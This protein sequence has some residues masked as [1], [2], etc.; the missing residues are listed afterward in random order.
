[1]DKK[2]F[3]QSFFQ[4]LEEE[5][6][7][8]I[9]RNREALVTENDGEVDII[10]PEK[11]LDKLFELVEKDENC[12][13]TGKI[14]D[15]T[16]PLL[17][18]AVGEDFNILLDFQIRGIGFCGTYVLPEKSLLENRVK[19]NGLN[20]LNR[21]YHFLALFTHS[22]FYHGKFRKY[23]DVLKS[24]AM[25][26]ENRKVLKDFY[27][28]KEGELFLEYLENGEFE[29]VLGSRLKLMIKHF[30]KKPLQLTD[31]VKSFLIRSFNKF[32]VWKI[33][34]T[35]NPFRKAPV[36]SV[37]G[38]DRSGKSTVTDMFCEEMSK[39]KHYPEKVKGGISKDYFPLN[40]VKKFYKSLDSKGEEDVYEKS[41]SSS[42]G[43][44]FSV[45]KKVYWVLNGFITS[46]IVFYHSQRGRCVVMDRHSSDL[47]FFY[48][49]EGFWESLVKFLGPKTDL[50]VYLDVSDSELE[51]RGRE[52]SKEST[53][54]VRERFNS[55]AEDYGITFLENNDLGK[56][57]KKVQ[58]MVIKLFKKSSLP[59][60]KAS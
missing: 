21:S 6:G 5:V 51:K 49:F 39:Y 14:V 38:V 26:E 50:S 24:E 2:E 30:F 3:V 9:L 41:V 52:L 1:M 42:G 54:K 17:V 19:E 10:V 48:G 40:V 33:L 29:K 46:L 55:K 16:H 45:S 12:F 36:V 59:R 60:N 25:V 56:T 44:S 43:N 57:G 34:F 8:C 15:T 27:G 47:V 4:K 23:K 18:R 58:E 28:E 22:L 32:R 53:K 31:F 20:V 11:K 37:L 35:L 7:Y 13:V